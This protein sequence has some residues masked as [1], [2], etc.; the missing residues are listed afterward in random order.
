M[1]Y[2]SGLA[3]ALLALAVCACGDQ[4]S[5][6][7]KAM[8]KASAV[9]PDEESVNADAFEIEVTPPAI[10]PDKPDPWLWLEEVEGERALKWVR[11]R[12]TQSRSLLEGDG[13]FKT[14]KEQA[15][16]ILTAPD[17]IPSG[18]YRGGYVY[19]FWQ[20]ETHVRGI[21]RR[22]TL[23]SYRKE[24]PE[25]DVLLDIDKLADEEEENWVFKGVNCLPP[26]YDRCLVQLSRGGKDAA[27]F[28]EWDVP[29]R[30][31]VNRGFELK[32]AKSSV[33][34]VD[35][36][37]LLVGTDWGEGSLTSSGYPRIIRKWK[38]GTFLTEAETVAEGEASDVA[39]FTSV[40]HRPEG[41]V[42]VINR[43][44]DFF[45]SAYLVVKDDGST[46]TLPLPT[47]AELAGM[48]QG[49]ML[50][51]LR[52]AWTPEGAASE[53]AQGALIALDLQA[54]LDSGEFSG[55]ETLY[56]PD[57]R[58]AISGVATSRDSAIV[59]LLN[60]VTSEMLSFRLD[61][62]KWSRETIRIPENGTANISSADDFNNVVFVN[63]ETYLA[64]D[65]LLQLN[66]ESGE[67]ESIKALPA[68]F[69][70]EGAK[71]ERFEAESRDGTKV[72]YWVVLPPNAKR[73]GSLPTLLYGYG[74]FL[75]PLTPQYQA[76]WGKLWLENG[77][78]FVVA[79]I[80]GGGE[81]GPRWHEAG[82]K[83]KRQR[84]YDDFI[85]VAEDLVTRKIT[86]PRRLGISGR[87]NGGLLVGVAFT[88]R[89]DLFHAVVCGVPLLDMIRY[90]NL[91]PGA[92]WMGEYGD[93]AIAEERAVLASYSP[94]H[95]LRKDADYPN[96][97]FYT[98]TKDDRV[99]PGHAR[100]MAARMEEMGHD[101]LYY[102]NIEG[103]HAGSANLGQLADNTA[104]QFVYLARQLMDEEAS[105]Q[106]AAEDAGSGDETDAKKKTA[107]GGGQ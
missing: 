78:A 29:T 80:R 64:P 107:A 70:A 55:I 24:K 54:F 83:V 35:R 102:E 23:E 58:S 42:A 91:P 32:E 20:D 49:R 10:D 65:S 50:F 66:L 85:A 21:W 60:N 87:S 4:S 90:V 15:L 82:L 33:D 52:K 3:A 103:G 8:R 40:L 26:A 18:T 39:M 9:S 75:I 62:G 92:S 51:T 48:F 76:T 28:R 77:G 36:D 13:R 88:K 96:V 67:V 11:E 25:W 56:T 72:P 61:N 74:G 63:F 98:S 101:Y 22:A 31:F 81:F 38:R 16:A 86:S 93:P 79:N 7:G 1:R 73:D 84:V 97:F 99:H 44:I 105:P 46:V 100:K 47:H 106:E 53:I 71:V 57:E 2:A 12:N 34:W 6:S 104:L 41:S 30:A 95:N 43:A 89:P 45:N 17:R 69:N 59:S 27:V 94:Y 68:K 14:F 19:N 37:T 5:D